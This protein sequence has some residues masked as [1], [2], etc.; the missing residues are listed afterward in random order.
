[1]RKHPNIIHEDDLEWAEQS[2]GKKFRVRRKSLSAA[3]G[4]KK[5]VVVY[6]KFL[7]QKSMALSLSHGK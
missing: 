4:G 2:H 1:M 6:M 3:T 5:L 7:Q